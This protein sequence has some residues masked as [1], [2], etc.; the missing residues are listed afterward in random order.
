MYY[1]ISTQQKGA[2]CYQNSM[3]YIERLEFTNW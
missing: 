1:I 3:C 2:M